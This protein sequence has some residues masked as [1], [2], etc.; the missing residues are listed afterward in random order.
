MGELHGSLATRVRY[1]QDLQ[2]AHSRGERLE[3]ELF[4]VASRL[5]QLREAIDQA[6]FAD[7]RRA[8]VEL[9]KGVEVASQEIN[10]KNTAVDTIT[11]RFDH[12][13][14]VHQSRG[15][16]VVDETLGHSASG[17]GSGLG[18]PRIPNKPM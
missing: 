3:E 15:S 2:L 9:V 13:P 11:Y 17:A 8:V 10:G 4:S 14:G 7:K 12:I 1:R 16:F 6:T 18:E 5:A